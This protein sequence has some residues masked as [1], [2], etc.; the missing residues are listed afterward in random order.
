M[1]NL[2]DPYMNG[3]QAFDDNVSLSSC[4]YVLGRCRAEWKRGWRDAYALY[5]DTMDCHED[6]IV[7]FLYGNN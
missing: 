3:W 7:F 1:P 2:H 6:W 5:L 4:E